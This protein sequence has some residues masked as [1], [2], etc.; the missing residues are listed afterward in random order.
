MRYLSVIAVTLNRIM[1]LVH[2]TPRQD[3]FQDPPLDSRP[4]F[5]YWMPDA[6][7]DRA[8]VAADVNNAASVGA[9]GL[10]FVAF[11]NYGGEMGA[12][13]AD[14]DWGRNGFG[15]KPFQQLLRHSLL[16]H[17][18]RGMRMDFAIGPNQGQGVPAYAGDEG[19]QWDLV[20][21]PKLLYT[22]CKANLEDRSQ[23]C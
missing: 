13:P 18:K 19:L 11:F 12:Y 23:L 2:A 7:V 1:T 20:R 4:L 10:E 9:S 21:Q 17:K 3:S 14:A 16:E 22:I 15:T 8:A 5:R 6:G